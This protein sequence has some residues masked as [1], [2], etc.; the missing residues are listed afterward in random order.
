MDSVKT[1]SV[2]VHTTVRF[3]S[4]WLSSDE[5]VPVESRRDHE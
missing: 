2:D 4:E 5:L 1:L 3:A